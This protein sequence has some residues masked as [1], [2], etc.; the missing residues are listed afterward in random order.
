M[1]QG[2]IAELEHIH[3]FAGYYGH[4]TK[5]LFSE[6]LLKDHRLVSKKK[7]VKTSVSSEVLGTE[8]EFLSNITS[9]HNKR[10]YII[11]RRD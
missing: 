10:N 6:C 1:A 3:I 9:S 7:R 5:Y 11:S 2:I 8:A 4:M